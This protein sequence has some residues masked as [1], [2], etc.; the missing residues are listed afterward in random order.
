MA[1]RT[2]T[3][4]ERQVA[5]IVDKELKAMIETNL[6]VAQIIDAVALSARRRRRDATTIR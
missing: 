2:L 1:K 5:A 3:K 4:Q 6:T